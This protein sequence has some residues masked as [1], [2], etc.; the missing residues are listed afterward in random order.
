MCVCVCVCVLF[1]Q[2]HS[3]RL[4][5]FVQMALMQNFDVCVCVDEECNEAFLFHGT[6]VAVCV[7]VCVCVCA[8]V[9]GCERE[10]GLCV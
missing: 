5:R 3:F 4:S 2:G 9:G 7:C 6:R 1:D 8:S 10:C